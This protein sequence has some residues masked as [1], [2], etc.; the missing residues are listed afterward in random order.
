MDH[1]KTLAAI[2]GEHSILRS[3]L[4]RGT[5]RW[6]KGINLLKWHRCY[7]K[8]DCGA[9]EADRRI[10][11]GTDDTLTPPSPHDLDFQKVEYGKG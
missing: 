6:R 7:R 8:A 4:K 2:H 5:C 3:R 9:V 1:G 10:C 11:R